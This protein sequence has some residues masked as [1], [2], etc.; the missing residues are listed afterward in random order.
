MSNHRLSACCRLAGAS[1]K[2]KEVIGRTSCDDEPTVIDR[3]EIIWNEEPKFKLQ[4]SNL[5]VQS[6]KLIISSL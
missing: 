4:S 5:K 6:S 3:R 2:T 1:I